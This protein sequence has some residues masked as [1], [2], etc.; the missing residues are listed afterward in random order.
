MSRSW[1]MVEDSHLL[2]FLLS[3][4]VQNPCSELFVF[5]Q[6]VGCMCVLFHYGLEEDLENSEW[7]EARQCL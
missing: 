5:C 1:S 6:L 7:E 4:W 3:L 2:W